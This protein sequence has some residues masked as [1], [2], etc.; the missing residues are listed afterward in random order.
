MKLPCK[1][2]I[3]PRFALLTASST[4]QRPVFGRQQLNILL[5]HFVAT[6]SSS[7]DFNER[8]C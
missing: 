1:R 4:H 7:P 5:E 3:K 6:S 8:N 2:E